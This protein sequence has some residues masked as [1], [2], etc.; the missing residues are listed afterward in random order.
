MTEEEIEYIENEGYEFIKEFRKNGHIY[1]TIKHLY[2][3]KIYNTRKEAFIKVGQR[4]SC[5]RR[6]GAKI[7]TIADAQNFINNKFGRNKYTVLSEKYLG[8]KAPIIL[9]EV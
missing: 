1:I 9:K 2:C 8:R 5:Q 4:C 7:N 6:H 3:G